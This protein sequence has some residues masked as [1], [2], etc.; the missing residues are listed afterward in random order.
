MSL[1]FSLEETAVWFNAFFTIVF[2]YFGEQFKNFLQL[3]GVE[4]Y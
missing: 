3:F 2:D 4:Y 1:P